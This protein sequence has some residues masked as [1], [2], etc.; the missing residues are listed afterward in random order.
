M[1]IIHPDDLNRLGIILTFSS[2]FLLAPELLGLERV[3]RWESRIERVGSVLSSIFGFRD[4]TGGV[5][6]QKLTITSTLLLSVVVVLAYRWMYWDNASDAFNT[7]LIL[8]LVGLAVVIG[9]SGRRTIE[10]GEPE[11]VDD[12]FLIRE[13]WP[14]VFFS[15]VINAATYYELGSSAMLFLGSLCYVYLFAS[16]FLFNASSRPNIPKIPNVTLP[17]FLIPVAVVM[18]PMMLGMVTLTPLFA[19]LILFGRLISFVMDPDR[20]RL[21]DRLVMLGVGVF[22]MGNALQFISTY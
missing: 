17:V 14:Q 5:D 6:R 9:F 21:Q 16:V 11:R 1:E 12:P 7:L 13:I 2:G 15:F 8:S 4:D 19:A 3:Q 10:R 20:L 22:I 18:W